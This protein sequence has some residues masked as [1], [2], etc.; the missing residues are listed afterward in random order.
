VI[1]FEKVQTIRKRAKTRLVLCDGCK[2]ES[3]MITISE[4]AELF[5]T[6]HEDLFNFINQNKCHFRV[7][8]DGNIY[9]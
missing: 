7:S 2:A 5:E 6:D 3:D 4:A 9:L 8:I 1:E